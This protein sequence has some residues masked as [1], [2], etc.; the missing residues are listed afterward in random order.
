M[1]EELRAGPSL[2]FRPAGHDD[3]AAIVALVNS[4]Y[5]GASSRRGWTTE[6]D[7]LDGQRT[8]AAEIAGLVAARDS[9]I[10][11]CLADGV[12]AGSVH[13]RR[14][15]DGA[16][17]GMLVI[18]PGRQGAGLG[19]RLMAAAESWVVREWA[20]VRMWMTVITLR[21]ELIAFYGRRGYRRT[22][23]IV[24]FP[25]GDPRFGLPKVAGLEMEVL[26]KDLHPGPGGG[27]E[28]GGLVAGGR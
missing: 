5:R 15:G 20:C 16:Y 13:L 6:A 25:A 27:R 8:D 14:D 3:V 24:P 19:K 11:L 12:L 17:L 26:E 18:D 9:V 10:L 23:R 2:A 4:A 1:G 22:G 7:L 28:D 21:H